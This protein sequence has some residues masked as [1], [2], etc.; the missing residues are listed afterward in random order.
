MKNT[1]T[2]QEY[3]TL[4]GKFHMLKNIWAEVEALPELSY[5]GEEKSRHSNRSNISKGI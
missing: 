2:E 3:P 4:S 5:M 1:V